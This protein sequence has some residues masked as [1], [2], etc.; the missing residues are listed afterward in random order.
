MKAV[1]TIG[2]AF[3]EV[4]ASFDQFVKYNCKGTEP[5]FKYCPKTPL[6]HSCKSKKAAGVVCID[7]SIT[8]LR[9]VGGTDGHGRDG[10][11]FIGDF[12]VGHTNWDIKDGQVVCKSKFNGQYPAFQVTTHSAYGPATTNNLIMDSVNCNGDENS[13]TDCSFQTHNTERV[14]RS[15]VAGVKCAKCSS[16]DLVAIVNSVQVKMSVADTRKTIDAAYNQLKNQCYAWDCSK[17]IK[18][19]PEYCEVKAFLQNAQEIVTVEKHRKSLVQVTFNP[20]HYLQAQQSKEVTAANIDRIGSVA[21][22]IRGSQQSLASYFSTMADFDQ[23]KGTGE[24]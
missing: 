18:H 19:Y 20:R 16:K 6:H 8:N 13:L 11:V 4:H 3:G 10:N 2:S 21:D 24:N 5:S 14:D 15:Q 23:K 9:L 22:M 12:P 17:L 7:K 1:R